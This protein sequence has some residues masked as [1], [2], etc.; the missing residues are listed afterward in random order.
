MLST[1]IRHAFRHA[2]P[3][4]ILG[5]LVVLV[6]RSLLTKVMMTTDDLEYH[7]ARTANY[8]LALKQHQVPPRWAPN[9]NGGFGY[10]VFIFSYH[11]P[12]IVS[13]ALFI[14]TNSLQES[15]NLGMLFALIIGAVGMYLVG[16]Q[17]KL[18][19][20]ERTIVALVYVF[21]P[22][23]LL[24]VFARGAI[25][26]IYFFAVLPWMLWLAEQTLVSSTLIGRL[27]HSALLSLVTVIFF[28]THQTSVM[29]A[30][31]MIIFLA[32][33]PHA[34]HVR[35]VAK[36][37]FP[38]GIPIFFGALMTMWTIL[39]SMLE[40]QFINY[41]NQ[42]IVENYWMQYP[43]LRTL[44]L[45]FVPNS[46]KEPTSHLVSIGLTS[47]IIVLS[48]LILLIKGHVKSSNIRVMTGLIGIYVCS[49]YLMT[50]FSLWV[51]EI[52]SPLKYIQF[53]WRLLWVSVFSSVLL[54]IYVFTELRKFQLLYKTFCCV[55]LASIALSVFLYARPRGF[56]SNSD[57]EWFE[58]FKT[59]SSYDEQTPI[60]S[61]GYTRHHISDKIVIR[62]TGDTL[63]L[64]KSSIP[65]KIGAFEIKEWNG[66]TMTYVV[67]VN[68]PADIIQKTVYFPGWEALVDGKP[69]DIQY[70]DK[71]FPGRIIIPIPAGEHT[72]SVSF[73]NNTPARKAGDT[74]TVMGAV[75]LAAYLTVLSFEKK[76]SRIS[77]KTLPYS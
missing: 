35:D 75:G 72:I 1:R 63:F 21:A 27:A 22:Y 69:T 66:T 24:N 32:L 16:T 45:Q 6:F 30:L 67:L 20:L 13:S 77:K 73:T 40:K 60:W 48:S 19:A 62:K 25:G 9:L 70:N 59:A 33:V 4:L 68:Q 55:L 54:C 56:F 41:N 61:L 28:T 53:P 14:L 76:R 3:L 42:G 15:V 38:I 51:W 10:P 2:F 7:V 34:K 17:K 49:V 44:F 26:E 18:S 58:Y 8:Y 23:S 64:E 39:P 57:Y 11:L 36:F 46:A 47:F 50:P 12:Y 65:R 5:I 43:N 29:L 71:E 74:L 52:A 31:P 37:F